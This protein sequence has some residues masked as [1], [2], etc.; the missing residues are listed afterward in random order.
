MEFKI[1]LIGKHYYNIVLYKNKKYFSAENIFIFTIDPTV[2]KIYFPRKFAICNI[3][4]IKGGN[5][6]MFM[7]HKIKNIVFFFLVYINV[8]VNNIK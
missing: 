3:S 2:K 7:T 4:C 6:N 8:L 1:V 5:Q